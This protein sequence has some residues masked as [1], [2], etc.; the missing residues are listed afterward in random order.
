MVSS[1]V[2]NTPKEQGS[3]AATTTPTSIQSPPPSTPATAPKVA[4]APQKPVKEELPEQI[5]EFDNFLQT[6][7]KKYVGLSNELGGPLSEQAAHVQ[8][9]LEQERRFLLVATKTKKPEMGGPD[10]MEL[11]TPMQTEAGKVIAIKDNNRGHALFNHLSAVADSIG[12][13]AWATIENKPFKHVEESL[14]SA[15]YYGNRVLKEFREKCVHQL[16]VLKMVANVN[17][18]PKASRVAQLVL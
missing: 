3:L 10:F 5:E 7:V 18:G 8:K 17:Q 4:P 16:G 15:K 13:V 11:F 2:D 12:V 9:T 6:T 14:G 1:T